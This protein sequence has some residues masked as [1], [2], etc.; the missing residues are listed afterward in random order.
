MLL[1][2]STAHKSSTQQREDGTFSWRLRVITFT[3]TVRIS[4]GP[5]LDAASSRVNYSAT[6]RDIDGLLAESESL[7]IR[8]AHL[9]CS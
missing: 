6:V 4:R 3:F 7:V 1:D 2:A 5:M 8:A 9:E